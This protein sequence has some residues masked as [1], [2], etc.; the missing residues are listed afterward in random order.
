MNFITLLIISS[1]ILAI[2]LLGMGV[3][4]L[5]NKKAE[6]SGG[7]CQSTNEL[8]DRGITCGCGS[9][10][11]QSDKEIQQ[12]EENQKHNEPQVL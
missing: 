11:C 6:F 1:V 10:G 5:F 7:S 8:S 4:M 9:T 2:L 12:K 3:K